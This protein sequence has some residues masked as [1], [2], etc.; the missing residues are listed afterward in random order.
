[1]RKS[2]PGTQVMFLV[3]PLGPAWWS[4]GPPRGAAMFTGKGAAGSVSLTAYSRM[5]MRA[6]SR[7]RSW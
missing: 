7:S 6:A 2:P 4:A 3:S 5:S 1:M